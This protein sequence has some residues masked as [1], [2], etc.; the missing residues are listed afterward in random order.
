MQN[1]GSNETEGRCSTFWRLQR[2]RAGQVT[3]IASIAPLDKDKE[4]G[5]ASP[6]FLAPAAVHGRT[7][8]RQDLPALLRHP[9]WPHLPHPHATAAQPTWIGCVEVKRLRGLVPGGCGL[10]HQAGVHT[11]RCRVT[12]EPFPSLT[13][14]S[15][16]TQAH[17]DWYQP[18]HDACTL[19]VILC[20]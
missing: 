15:Q 13:A 14:R 2:C 5:S 16:L 8:N 19:I 11:C 6:S 4:E 10:D 20:V 12:R 9:H 17:M 3:C 7:G 1:G 18:H